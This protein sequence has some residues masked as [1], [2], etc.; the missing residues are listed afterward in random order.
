VRSSDSG[1][2]LGLTL[3][4]ALAA[5]AYVNSV[6][7]GFVM[8]D[9]GAIGANPA[10]AGSFAP[11]TIFARDFRGG[12]RSLPGGSLTSAYRPVVSLDFALDEQLGHGPAWT[13]HFGNLVWHVLVCALLYLALRASPSVSFPVALAAAALFAVHPLH[14]DAVSSVVGRADVLA[15]LSSLLV[16][17]LHRRASRTAALAGAFVLLCGLLCKES[18]IVVLP[19]VL[20]A[21]VRR[22]ELRVKWPRWAGYVVAF[23]V[24]EGLRWRVVGD[25]GS[26]PTTT[27]NALA[28]LSWPLRAWAG[29]GLFA[30][31][32]GLHALPLELLPDYGPN[33]VTTASGVTSPLVGLAAATGLAYVIARNW[34]DPAPWADA[35]AFVLV[36]GLLACN[37]IVALPGA[38]AERWWY[39]PSAGVCLLAAAAAA[40]LARRAQHAWIVWIGWTLVT[41]GF[42]VITVRRNRDWRSDEALFVSAVV[43]APENAFAQFQLGVILDRQERLDEALLHYRAAEAL[44]PHWSEPPAAAAVVLA[45]LGH[46]ADAD[47]AF[48]RMLAAG[49]VSRRARA[50]YVLYLRNHGRAADAAVI[51]HDGQTAP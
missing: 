36:P 13:F 10:V 51:E 17:W 49:H 25:L 5:G 42:F 39:L 22:G 48:A 1:K 6:G 23:V 15:A 4:V 21:D 30:H 3:V 45:R 41:A 14:T 29:L 20:L 40:E 37:V 32:L 27:A 38:F 26:P 33:V 50:N 44:Q 2:W 43:T 12:A 46:D 24:A 34:R 47:A 28:A 19:V 35:A 7:N 18:A 8:D 9:N 11:R 31:A 16:F